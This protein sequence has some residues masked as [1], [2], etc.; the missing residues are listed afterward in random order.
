MVN[1]FLGKLKLLKGFMNVKFL[2]MCMIA[3]GTSYQVFGQD[4]KQIQWDDDYQLQWSDFKSLPN[5]SVSQKAMTNSGISFGIECVQGQL[6]LTIGCYF[7]KYQSWVKENPSDALL[8]HERLHF[9]ITEL[10]TR[11]LIKKLT[12]LDDPCGKDM[13]KIQRIYDDNFNDYDAF[14]NR[15]DRE[16]KHSVDAEKQK[17]WEN[18][19]KQELERLNAYSSEL[20]R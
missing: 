5:K 10:Y 1:I 2:A 20:Y 14:Q 3:L 18:L 15:Y 7:D 19:V 11:K 8:E 16:T 6:D 12:S 9:D 4:D 13:D 17:Y